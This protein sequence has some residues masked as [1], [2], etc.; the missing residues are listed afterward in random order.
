M[1]KTLA[2][3]LDGTLTGSDMKISKNLEN[4]LS[5][6]SENNDIYIATGRTLH[7]GLFYIKQAK[8][9]R[10]YLVCNGG[11][12]TYSI[13][14]REV[15]REHKLELEKVKKWAHVAATKGMMIV[16]FHANDSFGYALYPEAATKFNSIYDHS[17]PFYNDYSKFKERLN[18]SE[19]IISL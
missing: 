1:N 8:L 14:D 4:L 2:F 10:G 19:G 3:D 16:V 18:V 7:L 12:I 11:A 6:Y 5:A 15:I 13:A 9:K 17:T